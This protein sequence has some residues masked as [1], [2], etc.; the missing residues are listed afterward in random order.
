ELRVG[1]S[2]GERFT[3]SDNQLSYISEVE[4]LDFENTLPNTKQK[5]TIQITASGTEY[6]NALT[7]TLVIPVSNSESDDDDNDKLTEAEER[8]RGTS[9]ISADTD[10]DGVDDKSD[11]QPLDS[12]RVPAHLVSLV[13]TASP[14]SSLL[15]NLLPNLVVAGP[16]YSLL[17]AGS[18]T[19]SNSTIQG[20]GSLPGDTNNLINFTNVKSIAAGDGVYLVVQNSGVVEAKGEGEITNLPSSLTNVATA[21]IGNDFAAAVLADGTVQV[22]GKTNGVNAALITSC[23]TNPNLTNPRLANIRTLAAGPDHLILLRANGTVFTVG[24]NAAATNLPT[25]LSSVTAVAAGSAHSLAL[26]TD[27]TVVAWGAGASAT[28]TGVWRNLRDVVAIAAGGKASVAILGNGKAVSWGEATAGTFGSELGKLKN[29][30]AVAV[31]PVPNEVDQAEA[32]VVCA[33]PVTRLQTIGQV[34][35]TAGKPFVLQNRTS[36]LSPGST[37]SFFS[38]DLPEGLTLN[39][40]NGLVTGTPSK[41]GTGIAVFAVQNEIV[42]NQSTTFFSITRGGPVIGEFTPVQGLAGTVVTVNGSNFQEAQV[43]LNGVP[44]DAT[45]SADGA[46]FTFQVPFGATTGPIGVRTATGNSLSSSN[47]AVLLPPLLTGFI[48]RAGPIRSEVVLQGERLDEAEEVVFTASGSGIT[49]KITLTSTNRIDSKNVRVKVPD[50]AATGKVTIRT[51]TGLAQ[52]PID[53]RVQR[54]PTAITLS[55]LSVDENLSMGSVV[56]ELSA[57]DEPGS[58]ITFALVSGIGSSENMDF[59]ITGSR[60]TTA[61]VF[62]FEKRN[63]FSIRIRATN[64]DGLSLEKAVT[65][66]VANRTDEDFDLDGLTEADELTKGTSDLSA[67]TDKDG[68]NDRVDLFPTSPAPFPPAGLRALTATS[69]ATLNWNPINGATAYRLDLAEDAAFGQAVAANLK[70][71]DATYTATGLTPNTTYFARVR[72]VAETVGGKENISSSSQT[73]SFLTKPAA[74]TLSSAGSSTTTTLDLSWAASAGATSY[75]LDASLNAEFAQPVSGYFNKPVSSTSLKLEGLDSGTDYYIRVRAANADGEGDSS[76]T[77]TR[78]TLPAAPTALAASS[79]SI[80]TSEFTANWAA[81]Q[82]ATSYRLDVATT[83]SFVS[84]TFLKENESVSTTSD[85][86]AFPAG[87]TQVFYRVRAVGVAG[88]S[89]DSNV[90]DILLNKKTQTITFAA[91]TPTSIALVFNGA[92]ATVTATSDANLPVSYSSSDSSI[93]SVTAGGVITARK[94]GT[95]Q[96]LITQAGNSEYLAGSAFLPV[97]VNPAALPTV[98]FVAPNLTYSGSEK[99]YSASALGVS[100]FAYRY[101]GTGSTAYAESSKPPTNVGT[102]QVTAVP[103]DPNYTGSASEP[104]TIS[105]ANLPTVAFTPPTSGLVYDRS[106][107]NFSATA[108]GVT[109]LLYLYTGASYT[110]SS[111][112]PTDIGDYTLTVTS[113]D[114][115]YTGSAS[116]PFTIVAQ[117]V[118]PAVTFRFPE[119]GLTYSGSPK[120]FAASAPGVSGFSLRYEGLSPTTYPESATPPTQVGTY[121]VTATSTDKNYVG[122]AIQV[123]TI[124]GANLTPESITFT[125]PANLTYD[126]AVKSFTASAVGVSGFTYSYVGQDTTVYG[127]STTAPYTAGKYQVTATSTDPNFV[128]K[129]DATFDIGQA[130]LTI[131]AD[132][133]SKVFG[134]P[135]PDLTYKITSGDLVGS[136]AL[137]GSLSRVAGEGAGT[138]AISSTLA[139]ANYE[140]AFVG[141]DL[142]INKAVSTITELAPTDSKTYGE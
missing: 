127:P 35:G 102:Y 140:I 65:I 74:P 63:S 105:P 123:F 139:N 99:S 51:P 57:T 82:G 86:V 133:Q 38:L 3:I 21:G 109:R 26:R 18:S 77:A 56:G 107:K 11:L 5:L 84:G 79:I 124:N 142:T 80:S 66:L 95:A 90:I 34:S 50:D 47:F 60:L 54:P 76:A 138:Y 117:T 104:F 129:K 103:T 120:S 59:R 91:E 40:T 43:T 125:Y 1:G 135:D 13:G 116:V 4:D 94:A 25:D 49:S 58:V 17:L 98:T 20:S 23:A 62:D 113:D 33:G 39:P 12:T 24:S 31:A 131:T 64:Q 15:T 2:E 45:F 92:T 71:S 48:P 32:V 89:E 41:A 115:N 83:A 93:F 27:R 130:L 28:N 85:V 137:T 30:Y 70:I 55:S 75:R 22:W 7:Q 87:T 36:P 136:D 108:N 6:A 16:G 81:V 110:D 122:S 88:T 72:T 128:G 69:G 53:F 126:G 73:F 112:A 97:V 100:D 106:P 134:Q 132:S 61:K 119:E 141:A 44:V 114:P 101:S 8:S 19:N 14:T 96:L 118:L 78:T 121:R 10:A 42:R 68:I 37:N 9:P 29:V 52:S 46:S 111:S 67:D